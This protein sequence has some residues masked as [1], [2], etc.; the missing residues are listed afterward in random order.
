MDLS[1]TVETQ[2]GCTGADWHQ[3]AI[4]ELPDATIT[5][6]VTVREGTGGHSAS[7]ADAGAGATY[8]WSITDGAIMAG[9][10]T[11][12]ITFAA[13]A[14]D[15]LSLSVT[16]QNAAGCP[17]N[18]AA[19]VAVDLLPSAP[20][21]LTAVPG[22]FAVELDWHDNLESQGEPRITL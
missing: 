22:P 17:S 10:G 19:F 18:G 4:D 8:S 9:A 6:P 20:T 7:V 5:A 21:G 2:A 15:P 3:V 1:V 13:D 14:I 16:V 12:A 11:S